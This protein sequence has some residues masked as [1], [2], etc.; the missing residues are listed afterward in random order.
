MTN[1]ASASQAGVAWP[2]VAKQVLVGTRSHAVLDTTS[3]WSIVAEGSNA[4]QN[5]L[6][7]YLPSYR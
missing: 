4:F 6:P 1:M 5:Y 2:P 3:T 7:A